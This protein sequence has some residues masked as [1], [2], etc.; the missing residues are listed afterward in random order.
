M[1]IREDPCRA[2]LILV[3]WIK[4]LFG[5]SIPSTWED[6]SSEDHTSFVALGR[7]SYW[8]PMWV[9][10][11]TKNSS[12]GSH[13][14]ELKGKNKGSDVTVFLTTEDCMN[15]PLCSAKGNT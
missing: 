7:L 15:G 10:G 5:C 9:E 12:S 14:V 6:G 4:E 11:V 13:R 3:T 8:L 1:A 2:Y